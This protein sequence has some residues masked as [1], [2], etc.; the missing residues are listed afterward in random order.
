MLYIHTF[1]IFLFLFFILVT[2]DDSIKW[3]FHYNSKWKLMSSARRLRI[4]VRRKQF[5]AN[6]H[7]RKRAHKL[8]M[9]LFQ[10]FRRTLDLPS[11]HVWEVKPRIVWCPCAG[12][13][14]EYKHL[15]LKRGVIRP[16]CNFNEPVPG[17]PMSNKYGIPGVLLLVNRPI[18]I[19]WL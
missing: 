1:P 12:T 6:Q 18:E 13:Q 17:T 8:P 7:H 9:H 10:N 11:S 4:P 14:G 5:N 15:R 16:A 3:S 2:W 19:A